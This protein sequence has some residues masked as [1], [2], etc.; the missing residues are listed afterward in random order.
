MP[1]TQAC[2]LPRVLILKNLRWNFCPDLYQEL[3][4]QEISGGA[5]LYRTGDRARWR[6]DSTLEFLGRLDFQVKLRGFRIELGEVETI[7][8]QHQHV[9]QAV[10]VVREDQPGDKRLVAY[11]VGKDSAVDVAGLRRSSEQS[12][13]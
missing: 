8:G 5:R 4:R 3:R 6:A 10:A 9:S 1:E 2:F 7:L 13:P 11:L 12:C